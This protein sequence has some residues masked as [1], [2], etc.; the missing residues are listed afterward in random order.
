MPAAERDAQ[1]SRIVR[2]I[3]AVCLL[4]AALNHARVLVQ[5]GLFYDYGG[6]GW[7]FSPFYWSG[8]TLLD[9]LVAALLFLRPR[10]GIVGTVLLI[11]SNVVHNLLVLLDWA[12]PQLFWRQFVASPQTLMQ[13]G[14]LAFVLATTPS[15]WRGLPPHP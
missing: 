2:G 13:V 11:A 9:P 4:L 14:F 10:A 1:R 8:L 6:A 7:W 5:H 15:A 3:W 12:G